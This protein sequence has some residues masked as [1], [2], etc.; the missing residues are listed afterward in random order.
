MTNAMTFG[1][2][3]Q[4]YVSSNSWNYYH[5]TPNSANNMVVSMNQTAG[6]DC[7]LYIKVGANPSQVSYDYRDI[8][9]ALSVRIIV[10]DPAAD[11][12]YFGVYG[13]SS[14][15]YLINVVVN[16]EYNSPLVLTV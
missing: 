14:C 8:G 13:F 15:N 10:P 6:G 9:V 1:V 3:V 5:I 7:D 2:N 16:S 12:W 4:G 11:T